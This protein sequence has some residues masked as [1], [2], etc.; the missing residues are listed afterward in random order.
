MPRDSFLASFR[1]ALLAGV[2][3]LAIAACSGGI[4]TSSITPDYSSLSQDEQQQNIADLAARY[5]ARPGDKRTAINYAA[6]LRTAGQ[7]A[8]AVAVLQQATLNHPQ[9]VEIS[10]AYA[11]ALAA[12]GNFEQALNVIDSSINPDSPSWQALNVKGAI[13]DQMRRNTEARQV[14]NQALLIA[15]N[16]A[17]IHANLGLSYAMTGDLPAAEQHLRSAVASRNATSQIRQNLALVLGLQGRFDEALAIYQAELPPDQVEANMAYIRSLLTQQDRWD[18]IA[19]T[20]L[21]G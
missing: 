11:K 21:E 2:A 5:Q 7:P 13:L 18:L 4:T 3:G 12:Q 9:D 1:I 8:Q 15:P 10:I 17:A 16:E 19:G 6:A 20:N 14:Y